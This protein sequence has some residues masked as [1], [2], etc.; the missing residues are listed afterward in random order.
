MKP[1]R[2]LPSAIGLAVALCAGSAAHAASPSLEGWA[3]MPAATFSDGPT[4]GQFGFANAASPANNPP[5]LNLQPVQGFSGVLQGAGGSYR[6][7]VDN[8]FGTQA[9]SADSL[10]RMYAVL[11]DFRTASGGSGTVS[12]ADWA[13]GAA[14]A[15]FDASTRITLSDPNRKLGFAIQADYAQYYNGSA[16][17]N[18]KGIAVDAGIRANQLLTGADLDTESVRQ[19][20][21]GHLWFGDEFGPYLVKTD[22][23]GKVLAR[24]VSLPGVYAPE[25]AYRG[26]APA[27]LGGSRGFEGMAINKGGDR[28]YTLLEGTVTGDP[29][30]TLRIN[31]F[32]IDT[33]AYAAGSWLYKLD[34]NG[35]NIGDMTAI[36]DH[37]FIVIERNGATATGG[38]PFKKL[39]KVDLSKVGADGTVEKTELVDLMNIADPSDLNGDGSTTFTF[40]YVTI[41]NVHVVDAHTLLMVN[42]NNFPGGGGRALTSDNTEFLKIHLDQ[43]LNVSPVPEPASVALMLGGLVLIG[44]KVRN[45]QHRRP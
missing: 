22:A 35:T 26:A 32:N 5:Y 33:N 1:T 29:A 6:F 38:T 36:N 7:L 28:L 41:E 23:T 11:P 10:L 19:D 42:D 43:A 45:G 14:R 8:G 25:N 24:D 4:S 27:N 16:S 44:L 15:G 39:F 9:S 20:K 18:P 13:T 21:Y 2:L 12:A 40:P 34:A 31:E 3:V 17:L 37:E 30:K